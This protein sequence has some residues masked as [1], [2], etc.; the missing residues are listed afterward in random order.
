MPEPR[1]RDAVA[2]WRR[3]VARLPRPAAVASEDPWYAQLAAD[4]IEVWGALFTAEELNLGPVSE[5]I[6]ALLYTGFAA[7]PRRDIDMDRLRAMLALTQISNY[8]YPTLRGSFSAVSKPN[9]A[10]TYALE[11]SRRDL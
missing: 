8:M 7:P 3:A 1:V 5:K 11:S 2:A 9:V 4:F 10:S 6:A